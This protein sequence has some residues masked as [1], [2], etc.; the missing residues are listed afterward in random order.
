MKRVLKKKSLLY[1]FTI[2]IMAFATIE[3]AN[4]NVFAYNICCS[5]GQDCKGKNKADDLRCCNPT[6]WEADCSQLKKNY[7]REY[8]GY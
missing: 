5:L 3:Y 4:I 7:C 8:C 6:Q 2:L 1:V